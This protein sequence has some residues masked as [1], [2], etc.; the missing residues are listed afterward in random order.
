MIWYPYWTKCY[1]K[2]RYEK[3]FITQHPR[4]NSKLS[5]AENYSRWMQYWQFSSGLRMRNVPKSFILKERSITCSLWVLQYLQMCTRG[6]AIDITNIHLVRTSQAH[7]VFKHFISIERKYWT[8]AH[9]LRKIDFIILNKNLNSSTIHLF[10]IR[11]FKIIYLY[12][13]VV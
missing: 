10:T 13:L 6:L 4:L 7:C 5:T 2:D 3:D 8:H 12:E 1:Y 11:F 9:I